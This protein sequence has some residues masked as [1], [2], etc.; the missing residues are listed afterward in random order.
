MQTQQRPNIRGNSNQSMQPDASGSETLRL[1]GLKIRY[2]YMCQS[3][4]LPAGDPRIDKQ[5]NKDWY[6]AV[7]NFSDQKSDAFFAVCDGHGDHG[8]KCAKYAADRLPRR[9]AKITKT[10]R[11]SS[12]SKDLS[13]EQIYA[14]CTQAYKE[15]NEAMHNKHCKDFNVDISGTTAIS[16]YIQGRLKRLTVSNVGDSR[17][18]LGRKNITDDFHVAVPLSWDQNP[19]RGGERKRIR[20]AGGR[21]LSTDQMD[22]L[23]PIRV[24]ENDDYR[25]LIE[26]ET[27]ETDLRVWRK[28][29]RSPGTAFTRSLGDIYAEELGVIADPEMVT[30]ELEEGDEIIVLAS[31]GVFEFLT[32]QSVIDICAK[33]MNEDPLKA[34]ETVISHSRG[35]WNE[36]EPYIDD[37]TMICIFIESDALK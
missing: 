11:K 18:V 17:A 26:G 32:N 8:D 36:N 19:Y 7:K 5:K 10:E 14:A 1:G 34:C 23:A 12:A 33:Y 16:A 21:I 24:D 30:R 15:C 22:G 25:D 4:K 35:Y 3:G 37:M 13:E 27:E 29:E 28:N 6:C 9:L 31:D 20:E 2:G